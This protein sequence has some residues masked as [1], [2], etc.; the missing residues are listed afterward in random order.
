MKYLLTLILLNSGLGLL[1]NFYLC[2]K[3]SDQRSPWRYCGR[4]FCYFTNIS[5]TLVLVYAACLLTLPAGLARSLLQNADVIGAL[6][7]YMVVLGVGNYCVYGIQPFDWPNRV[8][9][10]SIHALAPVLT[11]LFWYGFGEKSSLRLTALPFWLI[12]PALYCGLIVLVLRHHG[13]YPYG[14]LNVEVVGWRRIVSIGLA[15]MAAVTLGAAL[16]IFAGQ[17]LAG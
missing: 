9:D 8:A 12:Y 10:L 5:N 7:L 14:F 1:L 2:F 4:Y 6:T 17:R 16:L 15:F 11:L 13:F 3:V